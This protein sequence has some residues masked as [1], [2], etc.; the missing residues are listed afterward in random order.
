[1]KKIN[2]NNATV[3]APA[4]YT[5]TAPSYD[6][7]AVN[8]YIDLGEDKPTDL[9]GDI[10]ISAWINPATFGEC[11]NGNILNNGKIWF[12]VNSSKDRV[13]LTSNAGS[14]FA[15]SQ[16]DPTF[17]NVWQHVLVTRPSSGSG[18]K[19]YINGADV[20]DSG[21][22]G[23]PEAGTTNTYIGNRNNSGDFDRTFDG[24]ISGMK[25][26][27]RILDTNE[28]EYLYESEKHNYQNVT[29]E[30]PSEYELV[31]EF[32][33]NASDTS[34]LQLKDL[35]ENSCLV[36]WGDG[37]LQEISTS[38]ETTSRIVPSKVKI[39]SR[40]GLDYF[41]SSNN[42]FDFNL[43]I[44]PTS[45][46]NFRCTGSNTVSGDLADLPTSLT[47]FLCYGSNTVSGDLADLPTSLTYFICSG[48][49]TVSGDLAD[50]PTNLTSFSCY[51]SNTV[52]G[53]LADL[54]TNLI[55]FFC[56]GSNTVSGD[57]ADLPTNLI[58]FLCYGNNT[59]S[60][61]LVSLPTSLTNFRCTG[62]N[63]VSGDLADLPTNLTYFRCSGSNT[64]STYTSP[65]TFNSSINYF[66]LLPATG[67]GLD[68]T[69]VDNLLID[70][71]ASGMSRGTIDIS[72]NNAARTSASD[73]AI[74]SLTGNGV[75]VTTN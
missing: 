60:G 39:Y 9:T 18:V 27:N 15:V 54:P 25:I 44:L 38:S 32:D 20:T 66:L 72:G 12:Y 62:S 43:N 13:Q 23:T 51:G 70:L 10:T 16:I 30:I 42:N 6:F 59:I 35:D 37:I 8:D 50:L 52:S 7:D 61:D 14:N 5:T 75:S 19:F 36:D 74:A 29:Y 33:D 68:S 17:L 48:S 56:S 4:V 55:V 40:N 67:Y 64:V 24:Q 21:V 57:L 73:A 46:T 71:D 31:M 45:L 58:V 49:N 2:L 47:Y 3:V 41:N 28:I 26:W 65:H 11:G 34:T 1:M 69:E 22:S 63:T 53:D